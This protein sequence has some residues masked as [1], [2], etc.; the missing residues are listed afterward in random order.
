MKMLTL[1]LA[2]LTL[3]G[4][5]YQTPEQRAAAYMAP[6][7]EQLARQRAEAAVKTQARQAAYAQLTPGMTFHEVVSTWGTPWQRA[8]Q[9]NA[10]WAKL[11]VL[12]YCLSGESG[13]CYQGLAEKTSLTFADGILIGWTRY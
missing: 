13:Y 4:C 3:T 12:T 2:V 7:W 9:I 6:V 8:E 1:A 10:D 5:A 11:M